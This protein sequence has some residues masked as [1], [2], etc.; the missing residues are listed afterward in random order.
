MLSF[1]SAGLASLLYLTSTYLLAQCIRTSSEKNRRKLVLS[2]TGLAV[3]LHTFALLSVVFVDNQMVFSFGIGLSLIGWIGALTL[4][5]FSF[6]KRTEM[7]GIFMFPF[8]A[9]VVFM[10]FLLNTGHHLSY[11]L[12][13]HVFISIISYSLLGI[14]T[15]QAILYSIQE[16]RF[17]QK[18]LGKIIKALP[19]LQLMEKTL[20]NLVSIGYVFLSIALISGFFFLEDIFAQHL[21]H[22]TFFS[23]LAWLIYSWFIFGR[24]SFGWRGQK[25]AVYT[26][27]AYSLLVPSYIGTQSVLWFLG[28]K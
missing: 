3:L 17:Q 4:Q 10:P 9:L 26:I 19:P 27:V 22:K 7:L 20:Y 5:T 2:A 23:I 6:T 21:V 24:L 25:A 13:F 1:I 11:S 8:A 14:A 16:K 18:D 28:V 12:G 15:A